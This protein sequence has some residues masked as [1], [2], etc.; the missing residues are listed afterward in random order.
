[1]QVPAVPVRAH[2]R[3]VPVQVPLQHTPCWQR[4]ESHS[5]PAAQV[6]PSGFFE[7]TPPLQILGATQ[8]VFAVQ[9]ARHCPD[10]PQL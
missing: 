9:A 5:A 1:V 4:P 3:Q 10:A 8:S 7:Q 2:E 6:V